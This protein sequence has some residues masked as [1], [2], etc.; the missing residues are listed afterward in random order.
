MRMHRLRNLSGLLMLLVAGH[1]SAQNNG[2]MNIAPVN[3]ANNVRNNS[4]GNSNRNTKNVTNSSNDAAISNSIN[5]RP[6][7]NSANKL[8]SRTNN[9][10]ANN[11]AANNNAANNNAANNNAANNNGANYG[12]A[13][14]NTTN[15]TKPISSVRNGVVESIT[16]ANT[17]RQNIVVV[18]P[19]PGISEIHT[20]ITNQRVTMAPDLPPEKYEPRVADTELNAYEEQVA[21]GL[22]SSLKADLERYCMDYCS[23]LSL[24]VVGQEHYD[25]GN[26]DLGFENVTSPSGATRKFRVKK[27]YSEILVDARYGSENIDKLQKVFDRIL[28]RY[29]RPMSLTWSR[30]SFPENASTQKSEADVRREFSSQVRGQI[31]KIVTEFCPNEC[32]LTHINIEVDRASMDEAERGSVQRFLFTIMG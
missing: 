16:P 31:E 26:S 14:N 7:V 12:T 22:R 27:V 20:P 5:A 8:N 1:G 21:T 23:I 29:N 15:T 6:A 32:R 18:P 25:T 17:P 19:P 28:P 11:N 13:N 4:S 24:D 10:A 3:A 30:V 2:A 9:N